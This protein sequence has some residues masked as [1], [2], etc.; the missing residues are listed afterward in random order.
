MNEI[1]SQ[2]GGANRTLSYDLNGNITSDGS[3]RTFEW[4]A[5]NHVIAI[6]YT[7]QTTRS[8]GTVVARY[9][10]DPYGR[11]TT[12]LGTTPTELNF[13]GL[14]RHSKSNLDLAT[15]RAYDPNLG[16]WLNRDPIAEEGGINLYGYVENNPGSAVDPLGLCRQKG[17]SF[18]QCLDRYAQ[19]FY[20]P[21]LW[22]S[23]N[24]GWYGLGSAA[25]NARTSVL[26]SATQRAAENAIKDAPLAGARSG[27][28]MLERRAAA[29][30]AAG[31]A[32]RITVTSGILRFLSKA[33][34]VVGAAGTGFSAGA[35][36]AFIDECQTECPECP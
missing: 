27:G 2:S 32:S 13:T 23:D 22:W 33:S 29:A 36:M 21:V 17:E 19:D 5:A 4:D 30:R 24:L 16:R 8:T 15:F 31:A 9:D 35:R 11:S 10:Y 28:S 6:N 18:Y 7:G 26:T 12:V 34:G 3:T 25:V 1:V 14:Y 20:G